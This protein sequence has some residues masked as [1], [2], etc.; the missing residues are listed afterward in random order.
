[1]GAV[2]RNVERT[3]ERVGVDVLQED[4]VVALCQQG[5]WSC[6]KDRHLT[7]NGVVDGPNEDLGFPSTGLSQ[8][9]AKF[10]PSGSV[11]SR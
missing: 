3:M 2:D 4:G 6:N 11:L 1:M 8:E 9:Y 7:T 5:Y 10:L